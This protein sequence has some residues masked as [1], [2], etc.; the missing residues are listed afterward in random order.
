MRV[1]TESCRHDFD[2]FPRGSLQIEM[3]IEELSERMKDQIETL[4]EAC[5]ECLDD[6]ELALNLREGWQDD[7]VQKDDEEKKKVCARSVRLG[8]A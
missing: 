3:E 1:R 6:A 5:K 7:T 4:T 8:W 2:F